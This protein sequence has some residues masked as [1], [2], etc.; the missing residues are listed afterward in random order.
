MAISAHRTGERA[1]GSEAEGIREDSLGQQCGGPF[2]SNRSSVAPTAPRGSHRGQ[3]ALRRHSRGEMDVATFVRG[4]RR[5]P[6]DP[7][8]VSSYSPA[9]LS[10]CP[11][12]PPR[13]LET[14]CSACPLCRVYGWSRPPAEA[15]PS[16]FRLR[17]ISALRSNV[18][19][20]VHAV[21]RNS[22]S[23]IPCTR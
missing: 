3:R 21:S 22:V 9:F 11:W 7:L 20:P 19:A 18:L 17:Y 2:L 12:P 6:L 15:T 5:G 13:A 14:A 16:G 4:R 1:L 23:C 10:P 8:D